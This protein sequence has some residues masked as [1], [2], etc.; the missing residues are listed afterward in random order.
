MA[1]LLNTAVSAMCKGSLEVFI[2]ATKSLIIKTY[3]IVEVLLLIFQ[4]LITEKLGLK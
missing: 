2:N 1:L 4:V 3:T